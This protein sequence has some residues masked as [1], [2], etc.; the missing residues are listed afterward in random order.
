MGRAE[1]SGHGHEASDQ[2]AAGES[3]GVATLRVMNSFT[4]AADL[5]NGKR[6]NYSQAFSEPIRICV[7]HQ[8]IS[9]LD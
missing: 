4:R 8:V 2:N 5:T 3:A 6:I 1:A 7:L 9:N